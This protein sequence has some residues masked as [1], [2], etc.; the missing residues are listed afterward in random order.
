M[1][2]FVIKPAGTPLTV[3]LKNDRHY[4]VEKSETKGIKDLQKLA[5]DSET[6][7]EVE[8]KEVWEYVEGKDSKG[9]LRSFWFEIGHDEKPHG[10]G[11]DTEVYPQLK[12]HLK[13]RGIKIQKVVEYHHHPIPPQG[14]QYSQWKFLFPH[15]IELSAQLVW[16]HH[17]KMLGFPTPVSSGVVTPLGVWRMTWK[18]PNLKFNRKAEPADAATKKFWK[19]FE[20]QTNDA[21]APV[22]N[23]KDCYAERH[24][25]CAKF[26]GQYSFAVSS[27]LFE[28]SYK[29][30]S[31]IA[32]PTVPSEPPFKPLTELLVKS[33]TAPEH[34]EFFEKISEQIDR[35]NEERDEEDF[36]KIKL[37]DK[38][39]GYQVKVD[40]D[41]NRRILFQ[42]VIDNN[43]DPDDGRIYF[44]DT[45]VFDQEGKYLEGKFTRL[46]ENKRNSP[47]AE[48][49]KTWVEKYQRLGD[50]SQ[51]Q[52]ISFAEKVARPLLAQGR[53]V[54]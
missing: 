1:G 2:S 24:S 11:V 7:P 44:T 31:N 6:T 20:A 15:P 4:V 40:P 25:E 49:L 29:P 16:H 53:V 10:V 34:E 52:Q 39:T 46:C 37:R 26:F 18:G 45:F 36:F 13:E 50:P 3:N 33:I 51:A 47:I 5:S 23:R 54:T 19:D 27:K 38:E 12:A 14:T 43:S 28:A 48:K 17:G 32:K 21:W 22:G 42:Y 35:D 30:F 8:V 41:G 9:K